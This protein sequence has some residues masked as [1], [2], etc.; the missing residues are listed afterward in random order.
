M[1]AGPGLRLVR[2]VAGSVRVDAMRRQ[3]A[4]AEDALVGL[5]GKTR[6]DARRRAEAMTEE[7]RAKV[8][9]ACEELTEVGWVRIEP[10]QIAGL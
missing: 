3:R 1:T 7:E 6:E 4:D 2:D 10:W 8:L 9:A 5:Y